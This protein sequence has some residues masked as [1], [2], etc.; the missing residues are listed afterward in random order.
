MIFVKLESV[1]VFI[2]EEIVDQLCHF[3]YIVT[4]L[5]FKNLKYQFFFVAFYQLSKRDLLMHLTF[6]QSREWSF[7]I[8]LY[9]MLTET[10]E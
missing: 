10:C 3:R 2:W 1:K 6:V 5:V 4:L 7:N 8:S 9:Y